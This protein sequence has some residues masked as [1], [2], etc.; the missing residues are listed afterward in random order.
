MYIV[1]VRCTK[2]ASY[3]YQ[4]LPMTNISMEEISK[5]RNNTVLKLFKDLSMKLKQLR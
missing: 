2:I 5:E 4:K 3:P 1:R